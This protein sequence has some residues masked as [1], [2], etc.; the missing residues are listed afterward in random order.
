MDGRVGRVL[1]QLENHSFAGSFLLPP[2]SLPLAMSTIAYLVAGL[3]S[4]Q[5]DASLSLADLATA[6]KEAVALAA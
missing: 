3:A 6:W 2:W 5:L 1:L 4:G